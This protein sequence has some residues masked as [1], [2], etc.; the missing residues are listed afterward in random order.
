MFYTDPDNI[1]QSYEVTTMKGCN[2]SNAID[3]FCQNYEY[4][5]ETYDAS[6][7]NYRK[8]CLDINLEDGKTCDNWGDW[9]K[10]GKSEPDVGEPW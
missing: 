2:S 4:I 1:Y 6:M 9:A 5:Y 7:W 8:P 3:G 10:Y